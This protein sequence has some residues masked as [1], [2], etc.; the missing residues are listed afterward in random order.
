MRASVLDS[1]APCEKCDSR[2]LAPGR[3]GKQSGQFA[4]ESERETGP[5]TELTNVMLPPF[6]IENV[7][8][9]NPMRCISI[10]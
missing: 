3:G 9:A 1:R 7:N 10:H 8:G 4:G 6:D 5:F 2:S